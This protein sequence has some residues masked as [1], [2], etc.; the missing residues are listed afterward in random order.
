M[1][2]T[3]SNNQPFAKKTIILSWVMSGM[4][5]AFMLFDS[6]FK[7][8]QPKE[9]VDG[10]VILG[11]AEHHILTLGILGLVSIVLYAF[12]ATSFLGAILLTGYFGGAIATH[13]RLDNPLFSHILFPVYLGVLAWGGLWLRSQPLRKLLP[14]VTAR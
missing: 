8:I 14:G 2:G 9:V 1:K 4:V 13:L 12:P 11:F 7:F 6:L 3:V 10:T 5:I